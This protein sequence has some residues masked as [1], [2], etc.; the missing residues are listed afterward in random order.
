MLRLRKIFQ[1]CPK[2]NATVLF[3]NGFQQFFRKFN[4]MR[5][6]QINLKRIPI[7]KL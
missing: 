1:N 3:E 4:A 2:M 5:N 6:I 7:K